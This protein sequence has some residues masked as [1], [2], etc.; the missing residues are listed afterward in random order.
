MR[1]R[2]GVFLVVLLAGGAPPAIAEPAHGAAQAALRTLFGGEVPGA[3]PTL[4]EKQSTSAPG[5]APQDG[6]VRVGAGQTLS[7]LIRQH[8]HN[9][10]FNERFLQRAFVELNPEAFISGNPNALRKG[11]ALRVPSASDLARLAL[12]GAVTGSLPPAKPVAETR[13]A[14][15]DRRNWIRYP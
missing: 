13:D 14:G 15:S 4:M 7:A 6:L 3:K 5:P 9:S 2:I 12:P 1:T 10:P 11:A 8:F